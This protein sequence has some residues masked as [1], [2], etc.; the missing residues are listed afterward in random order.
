MG[1]RPPLHRRSDA[2]ISA[3]DPAGAGLRLQHLAGATP[4]R[5]RRQP[6][7]PT[8]PRNHTAPPNAFLRRPQTPPSLPSRSH[9]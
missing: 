3:V 6:C 1:G 4:D 9:G 2:S 5:H 7:L 8:H